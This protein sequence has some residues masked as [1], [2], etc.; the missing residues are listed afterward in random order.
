MSRFIL[1]DNSISDT[2]GHYFQYAMF[3]LKAVKSLGFEPV[4]V[5]NRKFS[6]SKKIQWKTV[7]IYHFG[8][9]ISKEKQ[10]GY[11]IFMIN[12]V[13]TKFK[14]LKTILSI[15]LYFSTFGLLLT[16]GNEFPQ[17]LRIRVNRN[18]DLGYSKLL[19]VLTVV[20][21][22]LPVMIYLRY[23]N[24]PHKII[25]KFKQRLQ[26][27]TEFIVPH[28]GK[29]DN[30]RKKTFKQDT[31]KLFH[32]INLL[33]NDNVFIPTTGLTELRGI[34][35]FVK[36]NLNA[37]TITWHF[38]FRREL[39]YG[40]K[41]RFEPQVENLRQIRSDLL[42]LLDVLPKEKVFFY[43]DT[44]ELTRQYNELGV[45][46]FITLPIPHTHTSSSH[47]PH[48][49]QII[50]S[51]LGDARTE[52]GYH[53][54][55]K[56]IMDLWNKYVESG[57]IIF[58]IQS[59]FNVIGG[60]PKPSVAK[61]QLDYLP[62]DK[63]QLFLKPLSM[64]EYSNLLLN[65]SIIVLPYDPLNYYARSSGIVAEALTVGIP[66]IVPS[67]SW[68]S[69]QFTQKIYEYHLSLKKKLTSLDPLPW[70]K[71]K[72]HSFGNMRIPSSGNDFLFFSDYSQRLI[73]DVK[74]PNA[75]YYLISFNFTGEVRDSVVHIIVRQKDI[76]GIEI[77]TMK[78][79]VEQADSFP[80]GTLFSKL[81]STCKKILVEFF[82]LENG[83]IKIS[84]FQL[85]FLNNPEKGKNIPLGVIG[86]I[87]ADE[88][89]VSDC[90]REVIDNYTHYLKTAKD[91]AMDYYEFHNAENLVKIIL[92]DYVM[93]KTDVALK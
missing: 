21:L 49:D 46:K 56:I 83:L 39:F 59:N 70:S 42:I 80:K 91:F 79:V 10:S 82:N 3:C 73:L 35:D 26:F 57:K 23:R 87:Y 93:D 7:P 13:L 5:T 51:Y 30:L 22:G 47:N 31:E 37:S 54:L 55:P 58:K 75:E 27:L 25:N 64:E 77:S 45:A 40:F 19:F 76:D 2:A 6:E 52:K 8:F 29:L 15:K 20:F 38:L 68:L 74:T 18:N 1:I 24:K 36:K 71:L 33:D 32:E 67:G 43:T 28:S 65:S 84:N 50:I 92:K 89:S 44:D 16:V 69:R 88:N 61:T 17:Y 62:S 4:L 60:E 81:E 41:Y 63:I 90:V 12:K 86:G 14:K 34:V 53:L 78:Y 48:D 9:W 72:W 11:G 66:V 85:D